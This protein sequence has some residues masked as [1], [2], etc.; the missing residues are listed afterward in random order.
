MGGEA[1]Y[2][3]GWKTETFRGFGEGFTEAMPWYF[4]T[5]TSWVTLLQ[6]TGFGLVEVR[7]P[8]HPDSGRPLSL[9]LIAVPKSA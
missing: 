5:L 2:R 4:R 9:L 7:E 1:P 6:A 8:V 3:D